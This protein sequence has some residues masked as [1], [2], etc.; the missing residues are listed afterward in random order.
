MSCWHP[1][2]FFCTIGYIHVLYRV[3]EEDGDGEDEGRRLWAT[4]PGYL[5]PASTC[6]LAW[7]RDS[8][9]LSL[10]S[11]SYYGSSWSV[12]KCPLFSRLLGAAYFWR[13]GSGWLTSFYVCMYG[14]RGEHAGIFVVVSFFFFF[15]NC[16]GV[17]SGW[18]D[19]EFDP[20]NGLWRG[21]FLGQKGVK[22]ELSWV[23]G[24]MHSDACVLDDWNVETCYNLSFSLFLSLS[25]FLFFFLFFFFPFLFLFF[26]SICSRWRLR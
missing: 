26:F 16:L 1:K 12:G 17:G 13:V 25:L 20:F 7:R 14:Q 21:V 4:I 10:F 9:F 24:S 8:F 11:L 18:V 6:I 23:L 2:A 19:C 3:C 22:V 5:F 15:S